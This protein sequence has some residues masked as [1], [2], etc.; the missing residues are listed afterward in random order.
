MDT[1]PE[2]IVRVRTPSNKVV[3]PGM[4]RRNVPRSEP[5]TGTGDGEVRKWRL[6][7]REVMRPLLV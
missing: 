3:S 6:T 2:R 7:T 5:G 4:G 1:E